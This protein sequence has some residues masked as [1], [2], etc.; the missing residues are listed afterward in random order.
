MGS[1]KTVAKVKFFSKISKSGKYR[2]IRIP[3][4]VQGEM[5]VMEGKT[6]RIVCDDEL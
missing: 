5:S 6:I 4:S 3:T 1:K 2:V